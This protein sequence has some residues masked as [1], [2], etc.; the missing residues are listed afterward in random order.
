[1]NTTC[2]IRDHIESLEDLR[3]EMADDIEVNALLVVLQHHQ[4]DACHWVSVYTYILE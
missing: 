1:M 3:Q 4:Q 2:N